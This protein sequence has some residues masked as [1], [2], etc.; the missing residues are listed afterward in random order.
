MQ[1]AA[2]KVVEQNIRLK[3]LL[4]HAGVED[5]V[6]QQWLEGQL[7]SQ[8]ILEE[9]LSPGMVEEVEGAKSV[10]VDAIG[11]PMDIEHQHSPFFNG[12]DG[13]S[14][15]NASPM[16]STLASCTRNSNLVENPTIDLTQIPTQAEGQNLTDELNDGVEFSQ[17]YELCI[18]LATSDEA[19]DTIT[20]RLKEGC[21]P[22]GVQGG[23]KVRNEVIWEV[24][25]GMVP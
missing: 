13:L 17:A 15:Q 3:E 23:C 18:R 19:A 9:H 21:T 2:L 6:V 1:I 25:D 4:K 12:L 16:P 7:G 24:L 22:N 11:E 10:S 14:S 5:C 8:G 20:R